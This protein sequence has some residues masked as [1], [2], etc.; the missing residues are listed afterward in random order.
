MMLGYAESPADLALGRTTT[1]SRTGDLGR[2][3]PDGL[4]EVVGRLGRV[5]KVLGLRLDLDRVERLLAA[6][7]RRG[8]RRRRRRPAGARA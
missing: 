4:W 8:R 1:S 7:R 6:A 5:A 3:R 2:L